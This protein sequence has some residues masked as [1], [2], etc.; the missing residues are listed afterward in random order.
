MNETIKKEGLT[1]M[2]PYFILTML[3][4]YSYFQQNKDQALTKIC[5]TKDLYIHFF[6]VIDQGCP[7]NC[8]HTGLL[9]VS[10][11]GPPSELCFCMLKVG[12]K[13]CIHVSTSNVVKKS[14]SIVDG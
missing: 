9:S 6:I 8:L 14:V 13:T 3:A 7:H 10:T 2:S 12:A 1:Y 5:I 11:E 4:F